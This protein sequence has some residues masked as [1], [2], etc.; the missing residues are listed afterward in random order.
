M[1]NPI[2]TLGTLNRLMLE[3]LGAKTLDQLRFKLLNQTAELL[4]Y[5]RAFLVDFKGTLPRVSGVSGQARV[6]SH[7]DPVRHV[8]KVVANLADRDTPRV[9]DPS[10]GTAA[11]VTSILYLPIRVHDDIRLAL[12]LERWEG[13][14]FTPE[15]LPLIAPLV[16]ALGR[17]FERHIPRK[18][19]LR[20]ILPNRP[21]KWA[22][23]ALVFFL[24]L[25]G[26][27]L[28]LRITAPCEITPRDPHVITA[29]VDGVIRSV[30]V[31]SGDGV[32]PGTLLVA[33]DDRVAQQSL[34]L[35][36]Q[37]V[38]ILESNL[39]RARMEAFTQPRARR[40]V[41]VLELRLA[42][43]K[44][45]MDTTA[46]QLK[47]MEIRADRSGLA[48]VKNRDLWQGRPVVVGEQIL[49]LV[50]PGGHQAEIFLPLDDRVD[51]DAS[52]PVKI[53]L[54]A[55]PE[56]TM[57]ARL[58][59]IDDYVGQTP[60]G[61][62]CIRARALWLEPQPSLHMGLQ[63]T[64]VLYGPRTSLAYWLIRKPLA[65]FRSFFGI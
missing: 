63:G 19:R 8:E 18:P 53:R 64:A 47:R 65:G 54:N 43:E 27:R 35:A 44:I 34:K 6:I 60:R 57:L 25:F 55:F 39:A 23:L 40:E 22:A 12:W 30:A 17:A 29:P 26:I 59:R 33:Y 13:E 51:F 4:P 15:Q 14:R 5:H 42:Q 37:Q 58:T 50:R 62:P 1:T 11:P 45:R 49:S 28:P 20:Y 3:N 31:D 46:N 41:R 61:M 24:L 7:A 32:E 9:L 56:K 52:R 36:R 21:A 48:L 38:R 10:P 2:Q 16:E